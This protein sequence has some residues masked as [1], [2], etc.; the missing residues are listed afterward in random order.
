M[1]KISLIFS[2]IL[3]WSIIFY[4]FKDNSQKFWMDSGLVGIFVYLIGR[5]GDF[6]S[7]IITLIVFF[8]LFFLKKNNKVRLSNLVLFLFGYL[9]NFMVLTFISLFFMYVSLLKVNIELFTGIVFVT[10][11][12][13]L[14]S[15]YIMEYFLIKKKQK[16]RR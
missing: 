3:I 16:K 10:L 9:I 8:L 1:K 4:I 13:S 6:I 7:L 14:I 5:L 2:L 11:I 15:F 12:H